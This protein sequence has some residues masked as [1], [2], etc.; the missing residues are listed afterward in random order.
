MHLSDYEKVQEGVYADFSAYIRKLLKENIFQATGIPR[1]QSTKNRAKS[2]QSLKDKLQ[3]RDILDSGAIETQIK[4]LAGVRL[5]FYTEI[6]VDRFLKSRLIPDLFDVEW[7]ESKVHYPIDE[8][9]QSRYQA[10]HYIVSLGGKQADLPEYEIFK[11][12]RCEIQIQTVLNHAWSETYHD[13]VYKTRD[14]DSFGKSARES[15]DHRMNKVMDDFLRPASHEFQKCQY[16]YE[17]LMLGKSLIDR[18]VLQLIESTDDNNERYELISNLRK[19]VIPNYDDLP[20]ICS[21]LLVSLDKAVC[22]AKEVDTKPIEIAYQNLP[23]MT[24]R[25]IAL[26]SIGIIEDIRYINVQST[27]YFLIKIYKSDM[28]AVVRDRVLES[29]LM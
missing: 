28:D 29:F 21:V 13:M 19:Y 7:N 10:F 17:R 1:L 2:L 15:L 23:R 26:Q 18:E 3:A 6:D 16:D 24:S 4:D 11:G 20:G 25:D 12:M 14:G 22:R 9:A 27:L 8:N 5:I